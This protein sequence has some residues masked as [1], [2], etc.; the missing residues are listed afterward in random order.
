MCRH[1]ETLSSLVLHYMLKRLLSELGLAQDSMQGQQLLQRVHEAVTD[2]IRG[3]V[4]PG[5]CGH[6]A[7]KMYVMLVGCC[8]GWL[9]KWHRSCM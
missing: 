8:W 5:Y 1:H 9:V 6:W 7:D 2:P 4:S 3:K